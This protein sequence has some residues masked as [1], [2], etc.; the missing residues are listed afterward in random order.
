[1]NDSKTTRWLSPIQRKYA[2]ESLY[3]GSYISSRYR[4]FSTDSNNIIWFSFLR[5][6]RKQA[7][8]KRWIAFLSSLIASFGGYLSLIL[9]STIWNCRLKGKWTTSIMTWM[10]NIDSKLP[11]TIFH[12]QQT[13]LCKSAMLCCNWYPV[14]CVHWTLKSAYD[15][16]FSYC[17]VR[18]R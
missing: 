3:L 12:C 6:G 7:I 18:Y 1:M 16:P 11:D 10:W 4:Q 9:L 8:E 5:S 14:Q 2:D 15:S 13:K 17:C